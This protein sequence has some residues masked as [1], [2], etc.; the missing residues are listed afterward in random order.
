M[1]TWRISGD[2]FETCSCDF[3]CPC[4]TSNMAAQP[5]RGHCDVA[6]VFHIEQGQYG[7]T[8]LDG[9]NFAVIAHAPEAMGKG[10]WAVGLITDERATPDQSQALAA[11]ASGQAGGPPAALGPLLGQFL[12]AEAKPIHFQKNGL[13]R[14]VSIPGV[15]DQACAGVPSPVAQGDALYIDNTLHP[16]NPRLA[17]AKA[18]RSHL[19][20]FGIQWN[21]TSGGNNG[22]FAPFDWRVN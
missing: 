6:M 15:L 5:S 19:S 20:A 18:T 22:H 7:G 14:S 10:G 11:I 21:D 16:A 3:L 8:R 13:S 9:L 1:T 17:L 4:I 12:G 2:Y